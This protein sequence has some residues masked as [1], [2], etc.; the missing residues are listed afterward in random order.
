MIQLATKSHGAYDA[1]T[2]GSI[3]AVVR[4][5]PVSNAT[6]QSINRRSADRQ[7]AHQQQPI[8]QQAASTPQQ[9]AASTPQRQAAPQAASAPQPTPLALPPLRHKVQKGQKVNLFSAAPS[10]FLDIY[11]GW[12][13]KNPKCDVDVS[14][15]LLGA[16]GKVLGESWFVFYG[17]PK[18]PEGSVTFSNCSHTDRQ[19][20]HIDLSRLDNSVKKI[21]FVLTIND[22][23][24]NRLHFEMIADAY[25]RI[26]DHAGQELHSFLMTEYYSN[27]ISMM[28]GEIYIHNE[29]WKLN[30]VGNGVAKDLAGLCELYGV[31]VL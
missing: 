9:Q 31:Q 5:E 10:P 20:M 26:I 30:A 2:I 16:D 22:A 14:A 18:S 21:V 3:N 11:F 13:V 17:Q 4:K 12:N 1:G 25:I 27:V 29:N 8:R 7:T 23:L 15:F 28:I 24:E 6:I 19:R